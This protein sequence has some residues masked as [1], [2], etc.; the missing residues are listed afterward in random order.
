MKKEFEQLNSIQRSQLEVLLKKC[1]SLSEIAKELNVSRQTIYRELL[2]NS[3]TESKDLIGCKYSCINFLECHKGKSS[4]ST[5]C[6]HNCI[7]YNPGRQDCLKKYP[8]T[9][10]YCKK[11]VSCRYLHY[12]YHAENASYTYHTRISE[13]NNIP[14]TSFNDIEK[15]NIIVS[16]LIKKGQSVEAIL[17]NHPEI[18]HSPLTIRKWINKGYLECKLSE[19]R[20]TGRRLPSKNYNYSKK[21]DYQLLSSR[22]IGHKYTDYLNYVKSNPNALI[23][24]LDTVIGCIDG[25]YSVLTIEIVKYKFQFGILLKE[26]TA[27]AVFDALSNIFNG[28]IALD[29]EYGLAMFPYFGELILTDNGPEFDS[30][31][32]LSES[33]SNIHVFYCHPLSSF[34]KGAC[35]R[36][37][38]LIRYVHYKGW[39]FDGMTQDDINI[40]FSN[41]N[42]YPRK[43]LKGKTPYQCVLEDPYLG[44]EFLDLIGINKVEC[45]DVI[46]NPSLL[47][48]IKK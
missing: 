40:L 41:I 22:K 7:K 4:K 13:A 23:I 11:R 17:F 30:I 2:R 32:S 47:K 36:N 38:V 31:L 16:P 39:S 34:E 26:H 19:L 46:L 44:K 48:K 37:H 15:I 43:T 33:N 28:L 10:N 42:S 5:F 1:K 29:N 8:F 18:K 12:Y 45:D 25:K 35:E 21:H 3:T 6:P 9:C 27:K 14:K 24:Q 20:M